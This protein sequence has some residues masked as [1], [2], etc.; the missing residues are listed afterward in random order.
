MFNTHFAKHFSKHYL[1]ATRID[2]L[3][4]PFVFDLYNA[5]VKPKATTTEFAAV[6]KL[7]AQLKKDHRIITQQ[8]M[9]AGAEQGSVKQNSI[10]QF[11]K[12]HAKPARIAQI[13]A[14]LI[15]HYHHKNIIE[16]GTSLGISA[17]YEA[18]ALKQQFNA[19]DYH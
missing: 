13:I 15:A 17:C 18:T 6:E 5:C 1:S 4:S 14:R 19:A 11:A 9:G 16:L 8:D 2:V 7:R 3:H 10:S 12:Q